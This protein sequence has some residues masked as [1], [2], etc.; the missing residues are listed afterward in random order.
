MIFFKQRVWDIL[1]KLN[2]TGNRD[3]WPVSFDSK[4]LTCTRAYSKSNN[5]YV[6]R[7]SQGCSNSGSCIKRAECS[8]IIG[9]GCWVQLFSLILDSSVGFWAGIQS[10]GDWVSEM[11]CSNPGLTRGSQLVPF[12]SKSLLCARANSKSNKKCVIRNTEP[13]S[14]HLYPIDIIIALTTSSYPVV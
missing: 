9:E 13:T 8:L 3:S 7:Q 14:Q 1:C 2:Q 10:A 12:D 4:S 11:P 5:K 6:Y